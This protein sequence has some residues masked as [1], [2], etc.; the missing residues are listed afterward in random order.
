MN[1]LEEKSLQKCH[2]INRVNVAKLLLKCI[3]IYF[4][5]FEFNMILK[6][7]NSIMKALI[8]KVLTLT[9]NCQGISANRVVS[10]LRISY[11][12]YSLFVK[13]DMRCCC[14]LEAVQWADCHSSLCKESTRITTQWFPWLILYEPIKK[15]SKDVENILNS[16]GLQGLKKPK[17]LVEEFGNRSRET[18]AM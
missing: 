18:I 17:W 14:S 5:V 7:W 12:T 3:E 10:P 8:C 2:R 9:L 1:L 11:E 16:R 15:I 13:C 4:C 6:L